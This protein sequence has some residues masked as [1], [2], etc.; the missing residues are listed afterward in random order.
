MPKPSIAG[1]PLSLSMLLS[2]EDTSPNAETPLSSQVASINLQTRRQSLISPIDGTQPP[3][4]TL[5]ILLCSPSS[6]GPTQ[7]QTD[8]NASHARGTGLESQ[9]ECSAFPKDHEPYRG[10]DEDD[11]YQ[12]SVA[13]RSTDCGSPTTPTSSYTSSSTGISEHV[14]RSTFTAQPAQ[15]L[16]GG[17]QHYHF[18]MPR[19][20]QSEG[21]LSSLYSIHQTQKAVPNPSGHLRY[22]RPH[23]SSAPMPYP[24]PTYYTQ[25]QPPIPSQY[26]GPVVVRQRAFTATSPSP[27]PGKPWACSG[28]D[29]FFARKYDMMRHARR[30]TGEKVGRSQGTIILMLTCCRPLSLTPAQAARKHSLD[31]TRCSRSSRAIRRCQSLNLLF[32]DV[33]THLMLSASYR[34]P[35]AGLWQARRTYS[36]RQ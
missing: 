10:F 6:P 4:S 32:S 16:I 12:T 21:N 34:N 14:V 30:H 26:N 18:A 23:S 1:L 13:S 2:D 3:P 8:S 15:A 7:R 19:V 20:S 35:L 11:G 22:R 36:D 25:Q 28:C 27:P 5:S 31:Q 29:Q 9:C 33:I 17:P 24:L